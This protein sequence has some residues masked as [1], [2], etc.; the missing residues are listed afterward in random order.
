MASTH[1]HRGGDSQRVTDAIAVSSLCFNKRV[2]YVELC[3]AH[4]RQLLHRKR[5]QDTLS[6]Y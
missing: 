2:A 4:M 5:D 6:D 1:M 3:E